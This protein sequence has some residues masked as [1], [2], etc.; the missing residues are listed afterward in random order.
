MEIARWSAAPDLADVYREA[1][2]QGL[3]GNLA[4][5]DAFGFT[6]I[7]GA[8]TP[9]QVDRLREAIADALG[10]KTGSRPDL[11][12]GADHP[13][14]NLAHY[15]LFRDPVFEE[16]LM[17]PP[18]ITL[19]TYLLGK[20]CLLSSMT[21]HFKGPGRESLA[22]HSD[23]GNG[24]PSPLPP[25]STV[26]NCNYAL[27]DYTGPTSGSLAVVPGSHAL[28]RH[29]IGRETELAIDGGNPKAIP[30]IAPA[31][32]A[33][34]WHANLWHGSYPR[35]DPGVRVNLAMYFCRRFVATQERYREAVPEKLLQRN[36]ERF[37]T[38]MG[39][40]TVYGWDEKG[41]DFSKFKGAAR[42][43]YD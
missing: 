43:L 36:S 5:L 35:V 42:S 33:V 16:A 30:V 8:L 22:L 29:P 37:A 2:N 4:E 21:S 20:S 3:E 10:D 6:I 26:A 7:E 24:M 38:L 23:A 25:W 28:N 40:D 32:S 13:E 27:S 12:T 39:M 15:L 17:N 31:G 34:I 14:M 19:I 9:G 18:V 11:A 1:R 41:P